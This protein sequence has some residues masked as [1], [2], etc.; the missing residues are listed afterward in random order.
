MEYN[1]IGH[2]AFEIRKEGK[3]L[4][5]NNEY[6][7]ALK[8]YKKYIV[9]IRTEDF[10]FVHYLG[11]WPIFFNE[12]LAI[13]YEKLKKYKEAISIC[14]EVLNNSKITDE[15]EI[16]FY[17]RA[18]RLH[19][20]AKLEF[21]LK[22]IVPTFETTNIERVKINKGKQ[23]FFIGKNGKG[24]CVEEVALEYYQSEEGGKWNGY[25]GE[26]IC[27]FLQGVMDKHLWAA[28]QDYLD[29]EDIL[30]NT[31]KDLDE[32]IKVNIKG[33]YKKDLLAIQDR[34]DTLKH[35]N[36]TWPTFR[37]DMTKIINSYNCYHQEILKYM[38][39]TMK[40]LTKEQ[41]KGVVLRATNYISR[42]G[43][44]DLFLFKNVEG[45]MEHKFVEVKSQHD[46]LS[47]SQ[48]AWIKF[49]QE[50]GMRVEVCRVKG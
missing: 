6:E 16:S 4:E 47:D 2:D 43:I 23:L 19:K 27:F 3:I 45:Y 17:K 50:N 13:I 18:E 41:L 29:F 21:T 40:T 15:V 25:W 31:N 11:S 34:M 9:E 10:G 42:S 44:P 24:L 35:I 7:K 30:D 33:H 14:M 37:E 26:K 38:P 32:L 20:K 36:P 5:K 1:D 46:K 48:L 28:F 39:A 8:L 22:N 49:L 12:R